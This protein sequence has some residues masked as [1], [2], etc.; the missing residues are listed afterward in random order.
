MKDK[1]VRILLAA[2]NGEAYIRPMIDSLLA[3]DYPDIQIILSDDQSKDQTADILQHYAEEYPNKILHHVSGRRFG[4][5]QKHF[6]YLLQSFCDAPYI[7]FCDQDDV[8]HPDKVRKTLERMYQIEQEDIVP[9]MVHTD[10]RVVDGE[11][12]E[13]S[14]SFCRHSGLDGKRLSLNQL[15]VQNVVTG[16]TMMIN[17]SLAELA[18]RH[19]P[20]D[21]MLMHDWWI[22]ILAAAFG[23]SSFLDEPT[24]DYRQHGDNSVGAKNVRSAAYL[25]KRLTSQKMRKALDDGAYQARVFAEGYESLLKPEDKEVLLAFASTQNA[26]MIARNRVYLKYKLLKH[27]TVRIAAQLLGL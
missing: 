7:M 25:W 23:K 6:M 13:I 18:C 9:A 17:R 3:Q 2:Y 1:T 16:C 24:I 4:C 22:A 26:S 10:L 11:L 8:W 14:P 27:G 5:A 12:K 19:I 21:G 15:L 20:E